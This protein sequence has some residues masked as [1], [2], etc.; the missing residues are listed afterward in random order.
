[1]KREALRVAATLYLLVRAYAKRIG[2]HDLAMLAA[3]RSMTAATDP[4]FRAAAA[5]NS[6]MVL[7]TR[8]HTEEAADL[9][10]GAIAGLRQI[11]DAG[12]PERLSLYGAL[13][14][15]LTVQEGQAQ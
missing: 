10:R 4:D 15:L 5:W 14:L 11:L 2:A 12:G 13:H 6:A 8:G 7:S 9:T 1:M 3:D